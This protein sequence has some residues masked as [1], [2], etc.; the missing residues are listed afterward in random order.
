MHLTMMVKSM[1]DIPSEYDPPVSMYTKSNIKLK[2]YPKNVDIGP[3]M[4][5]GGFCTWRLANSANVSIIG[6][7]LLIGKA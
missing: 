6:P 2:M 5:P 7:A 1:I 4:F 3:M